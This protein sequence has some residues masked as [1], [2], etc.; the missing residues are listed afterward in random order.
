MSTTAVRRQERQSGDGYDGTGGTSAATVM[1]VQPK[2]TQETEKDRGAEDKTTMKR[3]AEGEETPKDAS[4]GGSRSETIGGADGGEAKKQRTSKGSKQRNK[5]N[6][7]K[8]GS[9]K[10]M[11]RKGDEDESDGDGDDGGQREG[12]GGNRTKTTG[13]A[14][15]TRR[16]RR[17]HENPQVRS[18]KWTPR[19]QMVTPGIPCNTANTEMENRAAGP[20]AG[21]RKARTTLGQTEES[22]APGGASVKRQQ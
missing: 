11:K 9:R 3:E 14:A 4:G 6:K 8:D 2:M 7:N 15:T 19:R 1:E 10:E 17:H 13:N 22:D 12:D 18:L 16:A 20:T 5:G 21:N